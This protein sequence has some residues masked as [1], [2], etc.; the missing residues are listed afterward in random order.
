MS[1]VTASAVP[2]VDTSKFDALQEE[3]KQTIGTRSGIRGLWKCLDYNGNNIVSLAE[4]DKFV[5]ERFPLLNHKPALMRAYK[6]TTLKDGDG[7]SWVEKKEFRALL[8]NLFYFNKVFQIFELI[9][10]DNDRRL[11][12]DEFKNNLSVLGMSLSDEDSEKEFK[13][14]DKNNG[15]IVLFIEF[16]DWYTNRYVEDFLKES[17]SDDEDDGDNL[18]DGDDNA[19][20]FGR[21]E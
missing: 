9:D 7:D 11:T 16:C 5:I 6:K 12:M 15:G 17:E 8:W 13:L 14:I 10:E 18:N 4:I 21:K 3:I 1:V 19:N 2:N 20:D